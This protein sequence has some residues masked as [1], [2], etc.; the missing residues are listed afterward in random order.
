MLLYRPRLPPQGRQ[1]ILRLQQVWLLWILEVIIT[2]I[3][4]N[5]STLSVFVDA[6]GCAKKLPVDW[7]DEGENISV[8]KLAKLYTRL[9]SIP[10]H[11]CIDESHL[12]R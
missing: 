8:A 2:N 7:V 5:I 10:S 11:I 12:R 6:C 3:S 4:C 1:Q 9:L